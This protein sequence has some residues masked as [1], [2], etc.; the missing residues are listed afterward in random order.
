MEAFSLGFG[1]PVA[2]SAE[3]GQGLADLA[4]ALREIAATLP[5]SEGPEEEDVETGRAA[6][7]CDRRAA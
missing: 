3:H 6:Q 1:E 4:E 2:I 7:P 5:P